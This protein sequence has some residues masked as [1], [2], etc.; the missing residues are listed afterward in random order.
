M[1]NPEGPDR[2]QR[3]NKLL[4]LERTSNR[5]AERTHT[6]AELADNQITL[7][8]DP[9]RLTSGLH[10]GSNSLHHTSSFLVENQSTAG[11]VSVGVVVI[12]T[13]H[14]S[15]VCGH[16]R[17]VVGLI[18]TD[19]CNGIQTLTAV[20]VTLGVTDFTVQDVGVHGGD[21]LVIL[22]QK[23]DHQMERDCQA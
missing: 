2:P 14:R 9:E 3:V 7:I 11:S 19:A 4:G 17:Q 15:V 22:R 21:Q 10:S 1:V 8:L 6:H 13:S 5:S 23:M 12:F 16:E 20:H 18:Q